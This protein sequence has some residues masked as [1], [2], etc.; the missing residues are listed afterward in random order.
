MVAG[1]DTL[2]YAVIKFDPAKVAP[3]ANYNGFV[4]NG[5]GPNPVFGQ[6]ACKQGRTTGN[7]CGVTW[8]MGQDPGTLVMQVCGRPGDS[9]A[10][11][12]VDNLLVGMIH[13]AFSDALPDCVIKYIPLHTPAVVMSFPAIL[14]DINAKNRPG[15][16][17]V[18]VPA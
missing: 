10:P 6:V 7:S 15:A 18:P 16:G 17:F 1:N 12:T 5:V 13:G 14:A 8:G 9:G 11:V 4:I 2:D 3:V